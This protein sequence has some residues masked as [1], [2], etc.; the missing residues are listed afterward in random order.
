L[1]KSGNGAAE[2]QGRCGSGGIT[3]AGVTITLSETAAIMDE[4]Y[5]D[6]SRLTDIGLTPESGEGGIE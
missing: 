6:F 2:G 1:R 3:D 5:A 4:L